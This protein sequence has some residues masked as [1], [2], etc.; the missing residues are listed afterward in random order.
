MVDKRP[1]GKKGIN[2]RIGSIHATV[3]KSVTW[4]GNFRTDFF[5]NIISYFH[6]RNIKFTYKSDYKIASPTILEKTHIFNFG[7]N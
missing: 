2:T 5:A 4:L 6:K 3:T 1:D 7:L